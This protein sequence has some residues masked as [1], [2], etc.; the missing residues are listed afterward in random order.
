MP[1]DTTKDRSTYIGGSDAAAALGLS[2][3]QPAYELWL[4]KTGQL[5]PKEERPEEVAE[6]LEWG[7]E[8]EEAIGRVYSRRTGFPIRRRAHEAGVKH[9]K[10]PFMVAHVDYVITGQRRLMDSKNVGSIYFSQ[11]P[12]WGEPGTDQVPT[13]IFLQANHYLAVLD[14]EH[15]DIAA[16]VGGNKLVIYTIGRDEK[17][18]GDMI[19]GECEF[20]EMVQ[21]KKAPPLDYDHPKTLDLLQRQHRDVK[22]TAVDCPMDLLPYVDIFEREKKRMAEAERMADGCKARILEAIGDAGALLLPDG[23]SYGRKV[24]E[25]KAYTVEAQAYV[26]LRRKA[27]K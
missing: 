11:S 3:F 2:K 27:A 16:L 24:V 23:S 21:T 13:E 9:P 14:Y 26:E 5:V 18:I 25:K 12:E 1:T 8:M 19:E 10:Y 20:W 7:N 15:C 22:P 6:R 17:L 4:E